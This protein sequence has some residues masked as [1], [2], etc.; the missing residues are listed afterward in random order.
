MTSFVSYGALSADEQADVI[1]G[2]ATRKADPGDVI[3]DLA[4]RVADELA[5]RT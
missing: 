1:A 3:A 2:I 4:R 5:R